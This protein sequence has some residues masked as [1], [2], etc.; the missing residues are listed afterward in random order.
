MTKR[1]GRTAIPVVTAILP[2]ALLISALIAT[3][4]IKGPASVSTTGPYVLFIAAGC[5]LALGIRHGSASRRSLTTGRLRSGGQTLPAIP[6]LLCIAM[7][8]TTWMLCGV[9]PTLI[10]YGLEILNPSHFLPVSC[11]VCAVV[12]ILTGSSWSTI[13]TIGVAF[14]S[15]G[16]VLGFS[17]GWVAGAI[18]SG[19]YFGDKLSPLSDTTVLASSCCGVDL[20]RHIRYLLIT[21]LP[22]FGIALAVF[23][24]ANIGWSAEQSAQTSEIIQGLHARFNI[25]AATLAIPAITLL[26]IA[27]R[28]PTLATLLCGAVMGTAGIFIFQPEIAAEVTAQGTIT[29]TAASTASLLWGGATPHT[30]NAILDELVATRG[31]TGML[32]TIFLVICAMLFGA[33]MI[34]TGFLGTITRSLTRRLNKRLPAVAATVGSGLFLNACTSDQYL[35]IIIGGNM[36]R[37]LYRRLGMESRLL[38]RTLEDSVSVTSVII[39]W[40]S[41]GVTQSMVLGVPALTFIPYCVFNYVSPIMSLLVAWSGFKI[42]E[43]AGSIYNSASRR[44]AS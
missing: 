24:I 11:I 42:K 18:I 27:F 10:C 8:S 36:Y 3:I 28:V 22:A 16:S 39:P 15:I 6:M 21:S 40:N 43:A 31:I 17:P 13:A 5:A 12:S 25:S 34:G 1:Q 20:F 2:V 35:S 44:M 33:A 30:G 38:S 14:M 9:V 23:G 32:P 41:C 29:T 7:I 4:I 37:N 19:A 26:L